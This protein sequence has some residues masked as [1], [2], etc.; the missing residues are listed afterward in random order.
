MPTF[1]TPEPISATID[2]FA[3]DVQINAAESASTVVEVRPSD[4]SNAKDVK[5]AEL[6]TVEYES[7]RLLVKSAKVRR[8]WLDKSAG[9]VDVTIDLPSGSQ[10]QGDGQATDFRSDGRLG[11]CRMKTGV[12]SIWLDQVG[13][14]NAKSQIGD[15]GVGRASGQ[16]EVAAGIGEVRMRELAG[17]GEIKNSMGDTWVGTVEGDLR[18]KAAHGSIA[19]DKAE[20]DVTAKSANGSVR[21]GEVARGT[22]V[23]ESGLGDLDVGIREGTA[24]WLDVQAKG[25]KVRNL[26]DAASAPESSADAV[27][28]RG[29]TSVGTI[30]IRRA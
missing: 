7:G 22:V 10:A 20:A 17:D 29:R 19:V 24:A 13:V 23:A 14:L 1:N 25:G 6:T 9:S 28:V 21:L 30:V 18:V 4:P 11:D 3:G 15:I 26:L 8:T 16:I 12:G 27:R 2:V 5:S